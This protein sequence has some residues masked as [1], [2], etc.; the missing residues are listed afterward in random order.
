MNNLYLIGSSQQVVMISLS[1][2]KSH[3]LQNLPIVS[4]YSRKNHSTANRAIYISQILSCFLNS[5]ESQPLR[6]SAIRLRD[7]QFSQNISQHFTAPCHYRR[8]FVVIHL[9]LFVEDSENIEACRL[10]DWKTVTI[11]FGA[12]SGR[13]HPR[14]SLTFWIAN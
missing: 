2:I 10:H 6:L 9:S 7:S 1:A 11:F 12:L 14:T 5:F 4:K 3:V 13:G 8:F